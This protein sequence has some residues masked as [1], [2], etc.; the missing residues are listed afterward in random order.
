MSD[1]ASDTA[2]RGSADHVNIR[3]SS[4][5]VIVV[6]ASETPRSETPVDRLS[7]VGLGPD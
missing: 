6:F 5:L 7:T 4:S 3:D 1:F 2:V